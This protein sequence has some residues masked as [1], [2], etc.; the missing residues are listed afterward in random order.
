MVC[1][2]IALAFPL[3]HGHFGLFAS[4]ARRFGVMGLEGNH[5]SRL[6]AI[7]ALPRIPGLSTLLD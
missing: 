7:S 5:Q 6:L 2:D 3:M 1:V 4:H